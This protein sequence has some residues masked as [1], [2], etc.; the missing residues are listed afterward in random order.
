MLI[1]VKKHSNV[2]ATYFQIEPDEYGK[3]FLPL[4]EKNVLSVVITFPDADEPVEVS[5][6]KVE[7]CVKGELIGAK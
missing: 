4:T 6:L 3:F 7:V 2:V 1:V 5:S